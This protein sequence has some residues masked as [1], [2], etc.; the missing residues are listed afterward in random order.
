MFD[1]DKLLVDLLDK[2]DDD[3]D[4]KTEQIDF[5]MCNP[6]FFRDDSELA[7]VSDKI[8]KPEKRPAPHSANP[9]KRTEGVFDE[10]GEIGF[11]KRIIDESAILKQRIKYA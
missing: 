6:P 4:T 2:I 11:V 10:H 8:R 5:V 7:G 1:Q 9:V 3:D